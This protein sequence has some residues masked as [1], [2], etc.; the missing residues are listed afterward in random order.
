MTSE[1]AAIPSLLISGCPVS[2]VVQYPISLWRQFYWT[3]LDVDAEGL[4]QIDC[5]KNDTP[6][7]RCPQCCRLEKKNKEWQ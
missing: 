2:R 7:L 5:R 6:A 1:M 4:E 3:S